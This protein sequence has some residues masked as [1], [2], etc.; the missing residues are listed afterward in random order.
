[1]PVI[2]VSSTGM[3]L[4]IE[5]QIKYLF[6]NVVGLGADFWFFSSKPHKSILFLSDYTEPFVPLEFT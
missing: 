3:A 1:M 6:T 4:I 5:E 2:E